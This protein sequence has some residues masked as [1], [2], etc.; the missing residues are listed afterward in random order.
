MSIEGM[1]E[2]IG[3]KKALKIVTPWKV[4]Y[5]IKS[6]NLGITG[7]VDKIML[8]DT[9]VPI[10]IKTG[11]LAL[12]NRIYTLNE[13]SESNSLTAAGAFFILYGDGLVNSSSLLVISSPIT[14]LHIP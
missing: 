9:Y 6:E 10:E 11:K 12:Y 14:S 7:R 4:E 2:E 8:E 13:I 5:Y 3:I 1:I